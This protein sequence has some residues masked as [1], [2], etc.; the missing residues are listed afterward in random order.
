MT[1]ASVWLLMMLTSVL[2]A[3]VFSKIEFKIAS[4]SLSFLF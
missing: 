4:I 3:A 1:V 2:F